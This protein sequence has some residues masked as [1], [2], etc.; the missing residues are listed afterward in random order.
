MKIKTILA[1][2]S[3][4]L[5]LTTT[6][7]LAGPTAQ[8]MI[9]STD[10]KGL[11]EVAVGFTYIGRF[12]SK[13][14]AGASSYDIGV[15]TGLL[16]FEN[17]KLEV[18]FDY[19]TSDL[20]NDNFADKHPFYFNTKM[21]TPE[22]AFGIKGLPAFAVGIFGLGTYDKPELGEST[23]QNIAY[24]LIAKTIPVIGR[25]SAGGYYGSKQALATAYNPIDTNM[26]SGI[27]ASWDRTIAELSDKLWLGVD[28]TSGNNATG[29]LNVG[30][31]WAFSKQITVL[32][33]A[34]FFNPF[35]NP[36]GAGDLPGGK[37]AFT[38][39]LTLNLP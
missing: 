18:G 34:M 12:S 1:N 3:A 4:T 29:A 13:A 15:T 37:P 5:I 30:A 23:R 38:T 17:L 35:Y 32:I 8:I 7:A 14:D 33:G 9:P 6:T 20:Q 2:I 27:M 19:I 26:N 11:K 36:S 39:Q 16:P 10:I 25:L 24:G 28:Y 21:G 22:D 31:S